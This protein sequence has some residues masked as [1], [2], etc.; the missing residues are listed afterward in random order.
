MKYHTEPR[1][2]IQSYF[3]Q[4]S[5]FV[6]IQEVCFIARSAADTS[7]ENLVLFTTSADQNVVSI[8]I[9]YLNH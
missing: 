2:C 9:I 4:V 8:P 1:Y 7:A 5:Q 6:G 3:C